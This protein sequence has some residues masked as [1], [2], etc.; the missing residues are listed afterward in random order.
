MKQFVDDDELEQLET[1][2]TK[3]TKPTDDDDETPVKQASKKTTKVV[4]DDD[5][6]VPKPKAK[7]AASD[8]EDL[9][10][11]W[12]DEKVMAKTDGLDRIRP[13]KK[14]VCRI[15][16]LPFITPKKSTV[17]YIKGKGTYRCLSSEEQEICCE[18]LGENE[19]RIV[20]LALLYTNADPK[21][22]QKP[23]DKAGNLLPI[24]YEVGYVQLSRTN[25]RSISTLPEE[26]QTVYDI[27]I[28]MSLRDSGTG[29]EF[30]KIAS[31]ALYKKNPQLVAE[32]EEACKPF[33]DGKKLKNKLGKKVSNIE[34]KALLASVATTAEEANLDDVNDL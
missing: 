9:D 5:E 6:E 12:G 21:T 20:A 18:K 31:T 19:L 33:L 14:H 11:A 26:E 17:H 23:K 32:I 27:D 29:F 1:K 25:F 24:E 3:V 30:K 2:K 22:G 10:V 7:K 4:D 16:I 28:V 15:A 13:E 34:F 8:E